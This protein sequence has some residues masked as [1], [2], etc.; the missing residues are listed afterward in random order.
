MKPNFS[1]LV[2]EQSAKHVHT[3][4]HPQIILDA[5]IEGAGSH[6]ADAAAVGSASVPGPVPT[7]PH[8]ATASA[9]G[10][11]SGSQGLGVGAMYVSG[12]PGGSP[13]SAAGAQQQAG[14][15]SQGDQGLASPSVAGLLKESL[16]RDRGNITALKA[17]FER[18]RGGAGSGYDAMVMA[19]PRHGATREVAAR[20]EAA[21]KEFEVGVLG[22]SWLSLS[23][24]CGVLSSGRKWRSWPFFVRL[25]LC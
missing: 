6:D 21:R 18:R 17:A 7:D 19:D 11:G 9:G 1:L 12:S 13:A 24:W 10:A 22:G 23:G 15:G 2:C 8:A 20:R 3:P 5:L 25:F 14:A 4:S 16:A